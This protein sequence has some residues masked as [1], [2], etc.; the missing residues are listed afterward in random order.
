MDPQTPVQVIPPQTPTSQPPIAE[1][2][3]AN[4]NKPIFTII[5]VVILMT[6]AVF[7]IYFYSRHQEKLIFTLPI[8]KTELQPTIVPSITLLMQDNNAGLNLNDAKTRIFYAENNSLFEFSLDGSSKKAITAFDGKIYTL[9][10]IPPDMLDVAIQM[11]EGSISYWKVNATNG[12]KNQ[13]KPLA[14]DMYKAIIYEPNEKYYLKNI[15]NNEAD[16]YYKKSTSQSEYLLGHIKYEPLSIQVC[17]VGTTEECSKDYFPTSFTAS[18]GG[19]YLINEGGRGGGLGTPAVVISR[20]GQFVYKID[21]T[22]YASSAIWLSDN[23][24]LTNNGS[25]INLYTFRPDGTSDK[26]VI[27]EKMDSL[28]KN[29]LSKKNIFAF[30]TEDNKQVAIL[31][32]LNYTSKIIDTFDTYG[33]TI[34]DWSTDG[35]KLLYGH[36]DYGVKIHDIDT[37]RIHTLPFTNSLLDL[38]SVTIN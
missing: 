2:E 6:I 1:E 21:F 7:G 10:F 14:V 20:N 11:D 34:I 9:K 23:S 25:E 12:T 32:T 8:A 18:L 29:G 16:L 17:E 24:L 31:D 19:S 30:T 37:Q 38:K 33:I 28:I 5:A 26:K 13:F 4:G 35:T 3:K 15:Q 22:W 36:K 27:K